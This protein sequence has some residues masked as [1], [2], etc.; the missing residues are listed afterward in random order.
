MPRRSLKNG[1][2]RAKRVRKELRGGR[3]EEG[4]RWKEGGGKEVEGMWRERCGRREEG[5]NKCKKM[6]EG[7][8][9]GANRK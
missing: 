7:S 8:V 9:E 4:K 2:I 1:K 6:K 3:R 5:K